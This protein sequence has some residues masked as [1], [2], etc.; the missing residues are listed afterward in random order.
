MKDLSEECPFLPRCFK[1]SNECRFN[2]RPSLVEIEP[3]HSVACFNP[4]DAVPD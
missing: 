3:G 1:A 2:P 4:I